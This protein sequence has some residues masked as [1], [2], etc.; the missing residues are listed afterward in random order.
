M[1]H[2]AWHTAHAASPAEDREVASHVL[3]GRAWRSPTYAPLL[4]TPPPPPP[5]ARQR[6]GTRGGR[7]CSRCPPKGGTTADRDG[8]G[9]GGAAHQG[10]IP[11]GL[12]TTPLWPPLGAATP[13]PLAPAP[14]GHLAALADPATMPLNNSCHQDDAAADALWLLSW[15]LC[16]SLVPPDRSLRDTLRGRWRP[17]VC[18][19]K[20]HLK[21][22]MLPLEK[23]FAIMHQETG[24]AS[25]AQDIHVAAAL[26]VK[27][28]TP[29]FSSRLAQTGSTSN[30]AGGWP[31][32]HS[33]QQVPGRA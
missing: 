3:R 17:A 23:G 2:L 8:P 28:Y 9:V 12:A 14:P 20:E 22:G 5:G 10:S 15:N 6:G 7:G 27:G 25:R 21:T 18:I 32:H 24:I 26:R 30:L 11:A 31:P 33:Q 16:N 4:P 29:F 1:E 19:D 13:E